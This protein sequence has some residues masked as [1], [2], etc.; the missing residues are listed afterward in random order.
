MANQISW[1]GVGL[2]FLFALIVVFGTY[3]P[4]GYSYF[5]W[6]I[7]TLSP[8]EPLKVVTGIL[9]V[10]GWVIFIRATMRSL[11]GVGLALVAVLCAAL[12]WLF[13]DWGLIPKDSANAIVYATLLIITF[14]MTVGMSWSHVRR[15]LSGQVD[16]DDVDEND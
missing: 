3:N 1:S 11:G 16:M 5:H 9:F 7:Q 8:F 14:I 10:I 2:R 4:T 6:G 12:L 15:R 13:I